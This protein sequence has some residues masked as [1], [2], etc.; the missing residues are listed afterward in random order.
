MGRAGESDEIAAAIAWLLSADASYTTG[1]VL[2][3]AGGL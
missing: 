3:V 2:R 1:A